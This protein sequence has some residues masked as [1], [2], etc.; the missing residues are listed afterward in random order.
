MHVH[1]LGTNGW[2]NTA[3]GETSCVL[4][5]APEAYV[6]CD[7]GQGLHKAGRHLTDSK[8][9]VYLFLSHLHL[10]HVYGL[11]MLPKVKCPQGMTILGQP[12]TT[13][14]LTQFMASPWTCP[15]EKLPFRVT[16]QDI[17]EGAHWEPIPFTC[18]FLVHAD[19]CL[20]FRFT[21]DGKTIAYC[22]D[23]GLCNP[24]VELAQDADLLIV[25][26]A[27]RRRNESPRWPHLAPE[28]GA[29]VAARARAKQL[30]LIHFEANNYPTFAER[31]EA[32]QKARAIFPSTHA[33]RD[34]TTI[35]L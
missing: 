13:K 7:A 21:L 28:D 34:D 14:H 11:H 9:P 24:L 17:P 30:A 23:T 4:I 6:I 16:L 35:T 22:T 31:A 19:P 25:E 2:Y 29:D 27:W 1:F 18:R 5:D 10:D 32:E 26:C 12:G 3:T 20:G 8:K 15:L 33:M